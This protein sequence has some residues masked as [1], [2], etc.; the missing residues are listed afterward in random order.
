MNRPSPGGTDAEAIYDDE[1][2]ASYHKEPGERLERLVERMDL[3]PDMTVADFGCG[4][5]L[6]LDLL[7]SRVGV[8]YGV[9]VTEKML[10]E[11]RRR[12]AEHQIGNAEFL[13]QPIAD[14]CSA[15]RGAIDRA[16]ALDFT[17][18]VL[19]D[20]LLEILTAI[21]TSLSARGIFYVHTPNADFFLEILKSRGVLAQ[22]PSHIAVR[23]AE[24]NLA[25]LERAGFRRNRVHALPHYLG[26][27]GWMHRFT[28]IPG[29]GRYLEAR[30]FIECRAG[31]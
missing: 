14:F 4:S 2:V 10:D 22:I 15:H 24:A 7:R 23:N 16:F 25:L 26:S 29:I 5:G 19:D 6:L 20:E 13:C 21:R 31:L 3:A 12:Q 18:H 28:G 27:L 8:Y 1:Y 17:E 11:A 30:L 9:D